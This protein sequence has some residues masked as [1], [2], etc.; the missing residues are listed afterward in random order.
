[1][2]GDPASPHNSLRSCYYL[3]CEF[4]SVL[5]FE[6]KDDPHIQWLQMAC[7]ILGEK[8]NFNIFQSS[9][10]SWVCST[11]VNEQQDFP[12]FCPSG[13]AVAQETSHKWL[14]SFMNSNLLCIWC[15]VFET[16]EAVWFV[17]LA[18]HQWR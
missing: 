8:Y 16:S 9:G 17:V 12:V 11:L 3:P 18:N 4:L 15:G 14:K 5:A 6:S 10:I 7:A 2:S 13:E 1:M